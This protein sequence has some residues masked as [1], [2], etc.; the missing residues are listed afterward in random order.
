MDQTQ[1]QTGTGC[2]SRE[3]LVTGDVD[4][5]LLE[6]SVTGRWPE[7]QVQVSLVSVQSTTEQDVLWKWVNVEGEKLIE[8]MLVAIQ[9]GALQ[10]S[11]MPTL[12]GHR[13]PRRFM[14]GVLSPGRLYWNS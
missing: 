6:V 2:S 10:E 8:A 11:P 13:T 14:Y 3:H 1:S 5:N 7:Q 9:N 4:S 12:G